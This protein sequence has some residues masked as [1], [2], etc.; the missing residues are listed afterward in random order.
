MK[1][2]GKDFGN[3][4]TENRADVQSLYNDCADIN[5]VWIDN[6]SRYMVTGN[7]ELLPEDMKSSIVDCNIPLETDWDKKI[8]V[9]EYLGESL[10]SFTQWH[11]LMPNYIYFQFPESQSQVQKWKNEIEAMGGDALILLSC[12]ETL[13][14]NQERYYRCRGW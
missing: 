5:L 6:I 14:E 13:Q 10:P 2:L 9:T 12:V 11:P 7:I 3:Y 1:Y 4:G 8:V